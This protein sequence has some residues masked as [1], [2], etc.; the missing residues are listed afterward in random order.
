[1]A[2][3]PKR[4]HRQTA[5]KIAPKKSFEL[6]S[7][8]DILGDVLRSAKTATPNNGDRVLLERFH[9]LVLDAAFPGSDG[10]TKDANSSPASDFDPLQ[11]SE[12]AQSLPRLESREAEQM[13]IRFEKLNYQFPFVVL[14]EQW[15]YGTMF[16]ERPFLSLGIFSVMSSTNL[17]LQRRLVQSFLKVLGERLIVNGEKSLD[18]LQG[19]LVYLAW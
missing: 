15:S 1:V 2:A 13:L 5:H 17:T 3:R 4:A 12:R 16:Q 8:D 18:L 19:L 10:Y 6:E 7:S 11:L 9:G 14:P